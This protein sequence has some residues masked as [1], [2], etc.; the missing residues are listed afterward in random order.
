MFLSFCCEVAIAAPPQLYRQ[1][2]NESPVRAD[3]DDL[4]LLAGYG[5]RAGDEVVYRAITNTT[6]PLTPPTHVPTGSTA[7]TGVAAI[8]S[9]ASVPFSLTIKLPQSLRP[10]Q[11]YGLWVHTARGEWSAPVTINDARP[12]WIS[13]AFIYATR[14]VA[15]LPR[16]LK[17]VGRNLQ[18]SA[19]VSA[20]IKLIGP[21]VFDGIATVDA[22]S[23]STMD[24]YVARLQLPRRLIPGRYR[25]QVN[26]DGVSWIEVLGQALEVRPDEVP[27]AEYAVGDPQ[28]GGCRPD[29]A[30]D[31]T[32][33]ILRAVAAAK[34]A[35][36][37]IV[38]F[39]PGTW[40]LV[41]TAQPGVDAREGIVV[42][43]GVRLRGAGSGLTRIDRHPQ[44]SEHGPAAAFTL[45]GHTV[46]AGFRFRDLQ[47]YQPRDSAGPFLRLGE[48]FQRVAAAA[49]SST[50]AVVDEVT[51]TGNVFDKT[52][53]AVADGGLPINRLFITY[54]AFG[55]FHAALDLPGNR[56][57]MVYPFRVDDTIIDHNIFNPGSELDLAGKTGTIA[58]EIGAGHRLDFS[59]NSADG[60]SRIRRR[61]PA[62]R[63]ATAKHFRMT[64][65]PIPLH[66]RAWPR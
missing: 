10:N 63:S 30:G 65:M 20:R 9:S 31:D 49:D 59:G 8:V 46:V 15:S 13:P 42:P 45:M 38:Y 36:G 23:S 51:I 32:G 24:H 7:E 26:R 28:F 17:I 39:A 40:D 37:G 53:V 44:W 64:T 5:F 55:A 57:N 43:D 22:R 58:T 11:S 4:L 3:P 21:Q 60:S 61:A 29:D 52:F 35:G 25:V 18:P 27:A 56:F 19:G 16:E 50:V 48:E 66:S 34:L 41:T 14:P 1:P 33:C 62:T 2:A 54:N 47:V 6:E 12:L